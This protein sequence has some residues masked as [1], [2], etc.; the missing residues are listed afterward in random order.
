M[1]VWTIVVAGGS[2]TRFGGDRP[3]QLV[4][5]AGRRV[6]DW[7]VDVAASVSD[8]VVVVAPADLVDELA[9][10]GADL[11]VAGGASRSASVRAGLAVVPDDADIVIVHDA[12]RPAASLALFESVVEAVLAGA[13]GVIPGVPVTDTIKMV[14]EDGVVYETLPRE[15]LVAVQT[16]Q[17]FRADVLRQVHKGEPDATDDAALVELA[18]GLVMV[19]PGEATNLKLTMPADL[20]R[21]A[22]TLSQIAV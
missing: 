8:G 21:L 14:D 19:V 12:A 18:G 2:G 17:G 1:S 16:P 6:L 13:A 5:V 9:S 4:E 7:S 10:P 11:V 3:K 22:E 15:E 20:D